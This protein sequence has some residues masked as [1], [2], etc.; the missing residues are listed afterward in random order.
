MRI[1]TG[2]SESRIAK[3]VTLDICLYDDQKSEERTLTENVSSHGARVLT[4][5]A[6]RPGQEVVVVL[7]Q[8]GI[9]SE[10]HIVY[11][12]RLAPNKFAIGLELSLRVGPW[13]KLH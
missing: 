9:R 1:P 8:E 3:A 2:R 10:A 7:P 12:E 4:Q 11:C 13:E 5:H 6:M